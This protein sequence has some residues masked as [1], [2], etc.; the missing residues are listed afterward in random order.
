MRNLVVILISLF[1]FIGF[2]Q[3][4]LNEEIHPNSK[5]Y[6]EFG[7]EPFPKKYEVK[8]PTEIVAI[9]ITAKVDKQ[10][11]N[12]F[13][14]DN[15]ECRT[16]R[17]YD[18]PTTPLKPTIDNSFIIRVCETAKIYHEIKVPTNSEKTLFTIHHQNQ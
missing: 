10:P 2:S 1:P 6:F 5:I 12:H 16:T 8:Q 13:A 3:Q 11:I 14:L 15:D 7:I 18:K 9:I 17:K 4:T